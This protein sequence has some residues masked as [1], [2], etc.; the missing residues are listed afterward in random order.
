[1]QHCFLVAIFWRDH[2]SVL[3]AVRVCNDGQALDE[4]QCRGL[5]IIVKSRMKQ[6]DGASFYLEL[7]NQIEFVEMYLVNASIVAT[8]NTAELWHRG[9]PGAIATGA[10][11][12]VD[13]FPVGKQKA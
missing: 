6:E 9:F 2:R 13:N 5:A 10:I 7:S 4:R 8:M 11:V 1:M 12:F 3:S